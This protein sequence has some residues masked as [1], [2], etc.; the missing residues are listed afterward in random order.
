MDKI[1]LNELEQRIWHGDPEDMNQFEL[2]AL[3][4]VVEEARNYC[5]L[6]PPSYANRKLRDLLMRFD[7]GGNE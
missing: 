6:V 2:Q 4:D 1:D 3:V 5:A 7:F